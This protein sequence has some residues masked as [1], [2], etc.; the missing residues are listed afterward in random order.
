MIFSFFR[1][2]NPVYTS[3]SLR[4]RQWQDLSFL[5]SGIPIQPFKAEFTIFTDTSTQ[6]WDAKM[7]DFQ[8]LDP[9]RLQAPHQHFGAQGGNFGPPSLG[10]SVWGHQLKIATDNTT[11]LRDKGNCNSRHVC[12][13]LQHT[14]SQF[15]SSQFPEPRALATDAL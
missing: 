4:L 8:I 12:Y 6:V 1:C 3:A 5:T 15:M 9:F 14:S 2:D 11:D 10:F 13:S 7:G